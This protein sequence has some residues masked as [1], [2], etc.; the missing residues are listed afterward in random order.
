MCNESNMKSFYVLH[1]GLDLK[2]QVFVARPLES[3][4]CNLSD[5]HTAALYPFLYT[6][7]YSGFLIRQICLSN[8]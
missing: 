4:R 2:K 7:T 1:K 6:S 3:A 8:W 5:G